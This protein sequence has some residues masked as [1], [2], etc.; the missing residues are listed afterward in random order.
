MRHF[1][2]KISKVPWELR[3]YRALQYYDA[4]L[5]EF[6]TPAPPKFLDTRYC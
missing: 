5:G 1:L 2:Y 3:P 4:E 6:E